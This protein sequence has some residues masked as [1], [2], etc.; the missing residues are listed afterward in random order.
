MHASFDAAKVTALSVSNNSVFV[1]FSLNV[2]GFQLAILNICL[3]P[4]YVSFVLFV[5]LAHLLYGIHSNSHPAY[6]SICTV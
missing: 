2:C 4:A 1:H 6:L 3:Y 5:Y